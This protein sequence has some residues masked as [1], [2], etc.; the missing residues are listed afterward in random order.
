[1]GYHEL[2]LTHAKGHRLRPFLAF[3]DALASGLL[4]HCAGLMVCSLMAA[5]GNSRLLNHAQ[6]VI[7][8]LVK[9]VIACLGMSSPRIAS[10]LQQH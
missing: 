2:L 3:A 10:F 7:R 1:M 8:M 9:L 6:M 5:N 4:V